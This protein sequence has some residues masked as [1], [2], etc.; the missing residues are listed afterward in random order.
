MPS[1]ITEDFVLL[2][3]GAAD[4][5]FFKSL[6]EKRQGLNGFPK[7]FMPDHKE[8][9]GRAGFKKTLA[10]I[11]GTGRLSSIKGILIVADSHDDPKVTFR[12][13]CE[14]IKA[15]EGYPIPSNPLEV[16]KTAGYP[17]ISIMLL[18]DEMTPGSLETL[19]VQLFQEKYPWIQS[20]IDQFL[21]CGQ[22]LTYSWSPEK[23]GKAQYQCMVAATNYE[24]P[25]K[26]I[27]WAF[28]GPSPI[29]DIQSSCFD[30]VEKRLKEFYSTVTLLD[31]AEGRNS[32]LD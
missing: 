3:E 28:N 7:F 10:A 19:C 29:L 12:Y 5:N 1:E 18:P 2:C 27:R 16:A 30:D 22:I 13:I 9:Y 31:E 6:T 8:H 4:Q 17:A 20:C 24:D 15:A 25:S 26:A 14:Q 32:F 21:R 11:R 23:L